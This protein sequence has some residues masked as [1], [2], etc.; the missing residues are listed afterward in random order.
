MV[1]AGK[2][3]QREEAE[4]EQESRAERQRQREKTAAK[5]LRAQCSHLRKGQELITESS[6]PR[7]SGRK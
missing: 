2:D 6:I 7:S 5:L 4:S 1:R 3:S